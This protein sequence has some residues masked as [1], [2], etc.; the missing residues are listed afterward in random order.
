MEDEG[1][2]RMVR[3]A[4]QNVISEKTRKTYR[5]VQE[6]FLLFVLQQRPSFLTET[7]RAALEGLT[8]EAERRT[9]L[10]SVLTV[11]SVLQKN[12]LQQKCPFVLGNGDVFWSYS[13]DMLSL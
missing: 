6:R 2:A 10:K 4:E 9:Y 11:D 13:R 3:S 1:L 5:P 12:E 8:T 7:V